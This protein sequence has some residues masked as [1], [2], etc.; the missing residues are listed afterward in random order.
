MQV[1]GD[2]WLVMQAASENSGQAFGIEEGQGTPGAPRPSE[3]NRSRTRCDHR[4]G[5]TKRG[6]RGSNG[7]FTRQFSP[8]G[9]LVGALL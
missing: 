8:A 5:R 2:S 4:C 3:K 6:V 9:L 1:E 7:G